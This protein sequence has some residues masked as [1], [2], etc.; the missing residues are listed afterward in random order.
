MSN[1]LDTQ[2]PNTQ[3]IY[4]DID[5]AADA[6]LSR[7]EDAGEQPSEQATEEATVEDTQEADAPEQEDEVIEEVEIDDD[8]DEI[9]PDDDEEEAEPEEEED[10][11]E[12]EELIELDDE[13]LIDVLVDGETKQASIKELKRL[14]GQESSLTRKSQEVARQRKEAE[15]NIS[16]TSAIMQKMLEQA[17]ARYK[18]YAE[19]DFLVASKQMSDEDFA[20]LRK[21]A[22]QAQD[23]LKFLKEE[24]DSFYQGLQQQQQEQLQTAARDAVK[25]LQE[26]IPDWSNKLY[27]DI[28]AYAVSQGLPQEQVDSYVDPVVIKILHKAR[29]FD[30]AKQVTTT[31][32]KRVAKKVLKSKKAP[33]TATQIKARKQKEAEQKILRSGGTDLDDIAD[34]LLSRWEN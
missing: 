13:T 5:S 11:E 17:E 12:D 14:Y 15:D 32:K 23:D 10:D 24:A 9:D 25:V 27:D 20:L 2:N 22:Q 29:L 3:P 28:R 31:K 8:D 30:Q 21:E 4:E 1:V 7:W 34:L 33:E 19:V 26:D 6:L 16:K 18:P